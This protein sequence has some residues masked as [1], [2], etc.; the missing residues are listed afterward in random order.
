[1]HTLYP[2]DISSGGSVLPVSARTWSEVC[3]LLRA[4][5]VRTSPG[6]MPVLCVEGEDDSQCEDRAA[7]SLHRSDVKAAFSCNTAVW[8]CPACRRGGSGKA[9]PCLWTPEGSCGEDGAWLR[10]AVPGAQ[11]RGSRHSLEHQRLHLSTRR[12]HCAGWEP[13]PWHGLPRGCGVSSLGIWSSRVAW[14]WAPCLGWPWWGRGRPE[15]LRGPCPPPPVWDLVIC[16]LSSHL[17][18]PP[19]TRWDHRWDD[20]YSIPLK[21]CHTIECHKQ[22]HKELVLTAS[23]L[24]SLYNRFLSSVRL[25]PSQ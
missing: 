3:G 4:S 14:A 18:S 15:G 11:T 17:I 5:P 8:D 13:E 21:Y 22:L 9:P 23:H 16:H 10:S 2:E 7:G 20:S 24:M 19:E 12:H 1:M 25:F 6:S